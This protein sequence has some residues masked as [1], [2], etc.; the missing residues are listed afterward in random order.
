[1]PNTIPR[2]EFAEKCG[3]ANSNLPV[4]V[5]RGKLVMQGTRCSKCENNP[6]PCRPCS[7]REFVD[8][9][10]RTP[11]GFYINLDFYKSFAKKED[12]PKIPKAIKE[13]L[14]TETIFVKPVVIQKD[15]PKD[16]PPS[17][18]ELSE[19]SSEAALDKANKYYNILDK[20]AA[21]RLKELQEAKL[22]GELIPL[23]LVQ[24]IIKIFSESV[25]R[26]YS[27]AGESLIM[28]ISERL[29]AQ[30][31]DQSFMRSKLLDS[32]NAAIDNSVDAAIDKMKMEEQDGLQ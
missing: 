25:K 23:D 1:M 20:Q 6:L 18:D 4:Y 27:D 15:V 2:K 11:D 3:I 10:Y 32:T 24:E 22:K 17:I 12:I 16:E 14:V 8:L 9:D 7:S 30:A 28:V 31:H 29:G 5:Q 21:T 13:K 26:A 19:T